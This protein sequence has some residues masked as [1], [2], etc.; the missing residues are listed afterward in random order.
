MKKAYILFCKAEE[1]LV[2]LLTFAIMVL[3]FSGA[4]M[5]TIGNPINWAV[6][7]SLLIFAWL[8]FLGADVAI[9]TT[10]LISIDLVVKRFPK[11]VQD[12]LFTGGILL[13]LA[14]L[15]VLVR[16]GVPLAIENYERPFHSLGI[17]F[18]YATIAAPVG[19]FLMSVSLIIKLVERFH[20]P[21]AG[22]SNTEEAS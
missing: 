17:S 3:V 1:Y 9:R 5:R 7:L 6:D 11:I 14:F 8:I 18:S 19:S 10:G 21:I 2:A 13:S 15:F 20:G 12:I 16:Y 22:I 4:V